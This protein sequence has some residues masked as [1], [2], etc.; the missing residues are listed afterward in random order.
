MR[1][2]NPFSDLI[3]NQ[4]KNENPFSDLIPNNRNN[5][6]QSITTSPNDQMIN[7]IFGQ[8]P[9]NMPEFKIGSPQ[10]KELAENILESAAGAPGLNVV[11]KGITG[12]GKGIK[13]VL[14][15]VNPR[16]LALNVQKSHDKLFKE[17]SDIYDFIAK[18]VVPRGVSK[19]DIPPEIFK[20]IEINLPKTRA[21]KLL[22]QEAKKGDYQALH[23]L[24]SDLFKRGTKALSS[25]I[26]AERNIGEELLDT[27]GKIN[28][29]IRNRFKEYGQEDLAKLLDEAS[30]KYKKLKETY[31]SHPTISKLVHKE[32]RKMPVNPLKV[33]S[34]E[35]V[36]MNNLLSSHPEIT[37][38]LETK[39]AAKD[40][41][42]KLKIGGGVLGATGVVGG[43]YYGA[44]KLLNYLLGN[45]K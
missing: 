10:N 15:K 6:E 43:S 33:F 4:N 36:P 8:M 17:S 34:E 16:E 20:E 2:N 18:E 42:K 26:Q 12:F 44:N 25:D 39:K 3:P 24:Q 40:F 1:S 32:S 13:N 41:I 45:N 14:T 21:N 23:D 31:Y 9:K 38:A 22:L 7:T 11:S 27:R 30:G 28:D 5:G 35:S 19:I 29:A 37:K